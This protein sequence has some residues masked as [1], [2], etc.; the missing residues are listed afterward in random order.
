MTREQIEGLIRQ[1]MPVIG[2]IF[3][4]LGFITA[5]KWSTVMT[6]TFE[7]MGPVLIIASTVW[8]VMSKTRT[9]ILISAAGLMDNTGP[10]PVGLVKKIELNPKA[11]EAAPLAAATPTNVVLGQ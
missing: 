4:A 6:V 3:M 5:D 11:L 9:A 10:Q 1:L 2:G 8:S 7:L